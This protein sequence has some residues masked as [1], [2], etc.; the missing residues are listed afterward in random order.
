VIKI[1]TKPT[2]FAK[3]KHLSSPLP[4]LAEIY[5]RHEPRLLEPFIQRIIEPISSLN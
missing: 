3:N 5:L 4:M 1:I 2:L